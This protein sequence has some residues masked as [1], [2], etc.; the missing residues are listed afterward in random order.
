MS[1][2]QALGMVYGLMV[3]VLVGSALVVRRLNL[4]QT[5]RMAITWA[6]IFAGAVLIASA[7][8]LSR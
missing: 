6:I 7:L 8:G 1:E 2:D 5:I 3:L 4:G